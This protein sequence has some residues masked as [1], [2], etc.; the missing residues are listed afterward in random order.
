MHQQTSGLTFQTSRLF[1]SSL[2]STKP[3]SST[4]QHHASA[5]ACNHQ[6]AIIRE[7]SDALHGHESMRPHSWGCKLAQQAIAQCLPVCVCCAS[8]ALSLPCTLDQLCP[9][10]RLGR[11]L[12]SCEKP[13]DHHSQHMTVCRSPY[14]NASP[15]H[16]NASL[17]KLVRGS[18]FMTCTAGFVLT[19]PTI[20]LRTQVITNVRPFKPTVPVPKPV[21][22]PQ[23]P[24]KPP[25]VTGADMGHP[26]GLL[27]D[28]SA[29]LGEW[30]LP[31]ARGRYS[32][33]AIPSLLALSAQLSTAV[34]TGIGKPEA[35]VCCTVTLDQP[36]IFGG[37][38]DPAAFADIH[39][40]GS[41]GGE[42]NKQLWKKFEKLNA[43]SAC[44][45]CLLK[46]AGRGEFRGIIRPPSTPPPHPLGLLSQLGCQ[47]FLF[48]NG[49]TLEGSLTEFHCLCTDIVLGQ[50]YMML[51]WI[52][53]HRSFEAGWSEQ[54]TSCRL[55]TSNELMDLANSISAKVA[56]VLEE[57]LGIPSDRFYMQF[58]DSAP[59]D[60]GFKGSTF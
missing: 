3:L 9:L 16:T 24:V 56:A 31:G 10:L 15:L 27:K 35:Y 55:N 28:V 38:E 13:Q 48:S 60:F 32:A 11:S 34:T 54:C 36:I 29:C 53:I 30:E 57:K 44:I 52:Q 42:K 17:Q 59:S 19:S 5:Q 18:P 1:L 41:I 12:S 50:M 39:S 2:A 22:S 8:T 46:V 20:V 45:R 51:A 43:A 21:G 58:H 7:T 49:T 25:V 37:T 4:G 40:I 14:T 23:K 47:G 33:S 26:D 6:P